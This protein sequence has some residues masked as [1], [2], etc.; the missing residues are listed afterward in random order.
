[1]KGPGAP[2]NIVVMLWHQAVR[3]NDPRPERML[4]AVTVAVDVVVVVV[5]AVFF[6]LY[7]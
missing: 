1:L 6:Q 3:G 7:R 4:V 5:T 2:S